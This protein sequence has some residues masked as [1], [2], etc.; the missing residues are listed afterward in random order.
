MLGWNSHVKSLVHLRK[1]VTKITFISFVPTTVHAR[2]IFSALKLF[3]RSASSFF[4]NN[5]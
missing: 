1:H 5:N 2:F 4:S 3:Y